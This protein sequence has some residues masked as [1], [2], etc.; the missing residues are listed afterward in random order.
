MGRQAATL[1]TCSTTHSPV[2]PHPHHHLHLLFQDITIIT[3]T[4]PSLGEAAR[5][6]AATLTSPSLHLHLHLHLLFLA[7]FTIIVTLQRLREAARWA[8]A[9]LS[10]PSLHLHLHLL[11]LVI[12][13]I[14]VTL[15]RLREAARWAAATLIYNITI[16]PPLFT[17]IPTSPSLYVPLHLPWPSRQSTV[18]SC[19]ISHKFLQHL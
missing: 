16:H 10:S 13:T 2:P 17:F 6:A 18:I 14:I 15:Q 4:P 9:T 5:W 19:E 7:I 3:V 11:F 1:E 8:A 12:F